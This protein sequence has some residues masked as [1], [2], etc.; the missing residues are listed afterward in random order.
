MWFLSVHVHRLIPCPMLSMGPG[1]AGLRCLG[2]S[3][4]KSSACSAIPNFCMFTLWCLFETANSSYFH[5]DFP[6]V[7]PL[8]ADFRCRAVRPTF[9]IRTWLINRSSLIDI[10]WHILWGKCPHNECSY[11]HCGCFK[12]P[13][14]WM[15]HM[16][17]STW[18]KLEGPPVLFVGFEQPHQHPSTS[19]IYLSK[20]LV[21][22]LN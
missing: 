19:L 13:G 21:S 15:F 11:S 3:W 12:H 2:M 4:P 10:S 1:L 5:V 18:P 9:W 14:W 17:S 20:S 6:P 7:V 8:R 16:W 22:L